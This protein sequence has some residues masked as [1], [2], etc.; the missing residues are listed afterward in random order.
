MSE[1]MR[2]LESEIAEL[3]RQLSASPI[4]VKLRRAQELRDAY[5]ITDIETK[6]PAPAP[7]EAP[8]AAR[9]S[10]SG[11]SA[12]IVDA[13]REYLYG[14]EI[15]VPTREIMSVLESR[16]IAVGGTVPQ[17]SVSSLLSKTPDVISHGR[18]GWTLDSDKE[19]AGD[20]APGKDA[21]P[22]LFQPSS[23]SV[24]PDEEVAHEN[25]LNNELGD[26]L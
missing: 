9:P 1:F 5:A 6:G 22:A 15:P 10:A 16:G 2:A 14:K 12:A 8:R 24:E 23:T 25:N 11:T 17:N 20:D 3:E 7:R 4:Y 18:R 26:L 21:S 19:K 13:V